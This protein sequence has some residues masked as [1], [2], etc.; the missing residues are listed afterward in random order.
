MELWFFSVF[1]FIILSAIGIKI[2]FIHLQDSEPSKYDLVSTIEVP[3]KIFFIPLVFGILGILTG[4]YMTIVF[5]LFHKPISPAALVQFHSHIL[6]FVVGFILVLI[7]MKA[8]GASD[9]VCNSAM[10]L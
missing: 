1:F 9:S 10:K 6:F 5:K 8:I 7:S 4:W 3:R 2:S